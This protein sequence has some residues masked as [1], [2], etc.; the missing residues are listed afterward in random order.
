MVNRILLTLFTALSLSSATASS[1]TFNVNTPIPL[2][3]LKMVL[4]SLNYDDI[5]IG[6]LSTATTQY[7]NQLDSRYFPGID[8]A[9]GLASLS[10]DNV[11]LSV[12]IVPLPAQTQMAIRLD[13]E[14]AKSGQFTLQ[15]TELDSIS[16]VYDIWL[17]DKY[18][19]DSLNLRTNTSYTF[20]INKADT[21]SFGSNRF[22]VVIRQSSLLA[23]RLLAF[24][25]YNI[26]NQAKITWTTENE[27]NNTDF[28]VERSIDDGVT[29]ITLDTLIS[30]GTG[31]YTMN[32]LH[33]L[34][35]TDQYRL[36]IQDMN[37]V[38][39]Y[40]NIVTLSFGSTA[41]APGISENNISIYPNPSNGIINLAIN[42]ATIN[43]AA[44]SPQASQSNAAMQSYAA[45]YSGST[46]SYDIKI[47]NIRGS[48]IKTAT[49]AT[50][51]WQDN[52]SS[53]PP[54]TYIVQVIKNS[55]SSVV[56]KSTFVK[57]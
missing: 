14:A 2:L 57:L 50:T 6:F 25:A 30:S 46:A 13:V 44:A 20:N 12:N 37:G 55:D 52:I 45:A 29:F 48:V 31:Y 34:N 5:A 40:S 8:A 3:R 10:S 4:D 27:Q 41:A 49:S 23:M 32:D 11:A 35:G 36:K 21:N 54:G 19:K 26:A 24:D 28:T 42:T 16:Q 9:E 17:M 1:N 43:S 51:T 53:L 47:I 18:T 33:P 22:R 15:R 56:G 7:N 39:S 38:V